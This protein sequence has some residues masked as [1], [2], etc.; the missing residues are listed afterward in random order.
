MDMSRKA[1][2]EVFI[3]TGASRLVGNQPMTALLDSS[4]HVTRPWSV[5]QGLCR[6]VDVQ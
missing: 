6:N 1:V 5:E 4:S 2:L 3:F